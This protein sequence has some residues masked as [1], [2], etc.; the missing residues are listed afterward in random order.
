MPWSLNAYRESKRRLAIA[1]DVGTTYSGISYAV[2]DPGRVPEIKSITQF[3]A[4]EVSQAASKIPSVIYYDAKGVPRAFGAEAL[5]DGI[6]ERAEE[7]GWYKAEWFKLHLRPPTMSSTSTPIEAYVPALPPGKTAV[8]VVADFL[9]YL[10]KCAE[11]YIQEKEPN[12]ESL[13]SSLQNQ[14]DFIL[15]HP[16][17][18]EGAQQSM[19]RDAAVM[20]GLIPDTDEGHSQLSFVTEGEASLHFA[21]GEGVLILDAGGG[22]I[23]TTTYAKRADGWYEEIAAPQCHFNGSIFVTLAAQKY[24]NDLLSD[25]RFLDDLDHIVDCFD[26]TTKLRFSDPEEM[27]FVKFGKTK[28]NDETC[29]I[30]YGQL[31]LAGRE[32]AS[33]FEPAVRCVLDAIAEQ[34]KQCKLP[35]ISAG[36]PQAITYSNN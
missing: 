17:G 5:V 33:F 8:T 20:S 12:G 29:N 30:R 10:F 13:W 26:Q 15:T 25:S 21:P 23:D 31:K 2:L 3:P 18:W 24:L 34:Q 36:S 27:Q 19:M 7:E 9:G 1:F 28:D 11:T 14:I 35:H 4:Q 6:F 22:T 32:V 16:N